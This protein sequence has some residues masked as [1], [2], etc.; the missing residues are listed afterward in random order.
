MLKIE[1][2]S[3]NINIS[4]VKENDFKAHYIVE[5]LYRG[6]GHTIG[7]A[8]RRVLL[9]SIP[10]AAIKGIRIDGV[11]NEFSIIEGVKEAV[12]DIILNIK[13]VIVKT[14]TSGEKR[15]TL[16]VQGPKIVTAADIN[17]DS[18][19]EIINP[20]QVICTITTEKEINMEFLVDTGEGFVVAEDIERKDWSVDYITIDAI[21]T[22]IKRVS[23][24]IEDTM[25]G[26]MTDFDKLTLNVETDG[27]IVIRD[28][29]SYAVEL[30]RLHFDPF[31]D[32]GNGMENLRGDLEEEEVEE[33]DSSTDEDVLNLKIEEL[34]LTVRSF[35]CLKKAGIEEV[36]QLAIL[37]LNEL[38]KIKNLGRKSL[39]EILDKMKELGFDLSQNGSSE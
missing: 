8:L 28:A 31:L 21:Y 35:N 3:R 16:S 5:P 37:S 27:S 22:P 24:S 6:Y 26:R 34:D 38:L 2:H 12:T 15:M 10:G 7:N 9:S 29:I 20:D 33:V 1:K 13:E 18:E 11:L 17:P 39:D 32:I 23:Y 25:V 4:E 14:E 30:L 19:L 36:G